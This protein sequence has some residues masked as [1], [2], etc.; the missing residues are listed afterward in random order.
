[1]S[2]G[3]RFDLVDGQA[4]ANAVVT[5]TSVQAAPLAFRTNLPDDLAEA[6]V[7][8]S[9]RLTSQ[10]KEVNRQ[11]WRFIGKPPES[12]VVGPKG[13][14][15]VLQLPR[16]R[17]DLRQAFLD[18]RHRLV[19][20]TEREITVPALSLWARDL[21]LICPAPDRAEGEDDPRWIVCATPVVP[22]RGES[23]EVPFDSGGR[24]FQFQPAV[25]QSNEWSLP[26]PEEMITAARQK[27]AEL[28]AK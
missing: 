12:F 13:Y 17:R 21:T 18:G 5:P 26:I 9:F 20:S 4:T 2:S 3:F 15:G 24:E 7:K 11:E 6:G 1:M 19:E 28:N 10:H 23:G 8:L 14:E 16:A 25:L 27:L 22:K